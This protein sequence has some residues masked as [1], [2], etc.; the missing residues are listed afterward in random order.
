[1]AKYRGETRQECWQDRHTMRTKADGIF[2]RNLVPEL[3]AVPIDRRV[4]FD[5]DIALHFSL[6]GEANVFL[7]IAEHLQSQKGIQPFPNPFEKSLFRHVF[8]SPGNHNIA[9]AAGA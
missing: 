4:S 9:A 5:F 8:R 3:L 6:A 2:D 7:G 1:V